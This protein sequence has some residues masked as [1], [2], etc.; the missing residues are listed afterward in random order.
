MRIWNLKKRLRQIQR[1][2]VILGW[3]V[4]WI[5]RQAVRIK[6]LQTRNA[7]MCCRFNA[8]KGAYVY[9]IVHIY[10]R[11]YYTHVCCVCIYIYAMICVYIY[12]CIYIYP[13][14]CVFD[15]CRYMWVLL[16]IVWQTDQTDKTQTDRQPFGGY[17]WGSAVFWALLQRERENN[18]YYTL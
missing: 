18:L 8:E 3:T 15:V 16:A 9:I 7:T 12:I 4:L 5:G 13:C 10:T 17:V 2:S 11:I 1:T 6:V 14:I